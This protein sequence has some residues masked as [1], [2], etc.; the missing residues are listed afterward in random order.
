MRDRMRAAFR[1]WIRAMSVVLA[2]VLW[3]CAVVL[4]RGSSGV[5]ATGAF[6]VFAVLATMLAWRQVRAG[7]LRDDEP[8]PTPPRGM[9]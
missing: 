9:F 3:C 6:T 2:A 7:M 5:V 1:T 8:G 4:W